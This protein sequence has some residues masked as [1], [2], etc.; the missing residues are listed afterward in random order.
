MLIK[1]LHILNHISIGNFIFLILSGIIIDEC[2]KDCA[3]KNIRLFITNYQ[4]FKWKL[5]DVIITVIDKDLDCIFQYS[6]TIEWLYLFKLI[7]KIWINQ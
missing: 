4:Y 7:L 5:A 2:L 1:W 3:N 6:V